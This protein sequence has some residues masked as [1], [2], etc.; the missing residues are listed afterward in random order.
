VEHKYTLNGKTYVQRALVLGQ[1]RQLA[2]VLNSLIFPPDLSALQILVVIGDQLPAAAACVLR[3]ENGSIPWIR[4]EMIG[5]NPVISCDPERF[6]A[7][8]LEIADVLTAEAAVKVIEDFFGCNPIA[9]LWEKL[10][11]IE[12]KLR[13]A[14]TA[15]ASL[16]RQSSE[17]PAG[18]SPSAT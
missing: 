15:A 1:I 7:H 3:D 11:G 14:K 10:S 5:N 2:A 12:Q 16:T 13:Q 4:T 18:T 9:S 6:S 8:V 17:S